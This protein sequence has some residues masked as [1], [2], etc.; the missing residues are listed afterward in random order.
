MPKLTNTKFIQKHKQGFGII[1]A[2]PDYRS[3]TAAS[4]SGEFAPTPSE[5]ANALAKKALQG[6]YSVSS[7]AKTKAAIIVI[8]DREEF[9]SLAKSLQ[10]SKTNRSYGPAVRSAVASV[11][12]SEQYIVLAISLGLLSP[13]PAK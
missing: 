4:W 9:L 12:G 13:K 8:E 3:G 5:L 1:L 10:A 6:D 2:F 11:F 7:L